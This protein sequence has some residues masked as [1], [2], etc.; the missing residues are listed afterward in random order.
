MRLRLKS[1]PSIDGLHCERT[2]TEAKCGTCDD[3]ITESAFNV[4]DGNNDFRLC[5][6]PTF[7]SNVT[8]RLD[9]VSTNRELA[10]MVGR[11]LYQPRIALETLI[12]LL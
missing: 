8:E 6:L 10:C 2:E 5:P 12:V 7:L 3:D 4:K 11:N 9:M 1:D